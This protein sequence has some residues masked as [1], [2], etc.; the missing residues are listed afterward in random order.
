MQSTSFFNTRQVV[1]FIVQKNNIADRRSHTE[2]A[3]VNAAAFS[4]TLFQCTSQNSIRLAYYHQ[5]PLC[6][7]TQK[8]QMGTAIG[9]NC[10]MDNWQ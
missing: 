4:I 2:D 5:F 1:F 7:L 3:L 6:I 8:G 9:S 10:F